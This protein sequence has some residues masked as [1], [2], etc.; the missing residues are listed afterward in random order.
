[1]IERGKSRGASRGRR[2][3]GFRLAV[4]ALTGALS[5]LIWQRLRLVTDTP[6]SVYAEPREDEDARSAGR[7]TERPERAPLDDAAD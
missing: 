1:M 4:V 3:S 6:R 5:L 7:A 2:P